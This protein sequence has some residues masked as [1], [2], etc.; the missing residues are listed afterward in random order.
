MIVDAARRTGIMHDLEDIVL[1]QNVLA[2]PVKVG[3]CA[4][5]AGLARAS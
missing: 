4:S 5:G 2:S 3:G 1:I